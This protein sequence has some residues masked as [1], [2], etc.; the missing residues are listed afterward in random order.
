MAK[1][2]VDLSPEHRAKL[3]S[4]RAEMGLRSEA[5]ALRWIIMFGHPMPQAEVGRIMRKIGENIFN[6]PVSAEEAHQVPHARVAVKTPEP[7]PFKTRLKGEWK[8]P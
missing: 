3:D 4:L 5:E 6:T 1:F 7:A 8:A 2:V